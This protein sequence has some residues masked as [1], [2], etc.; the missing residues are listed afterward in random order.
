MKNKKIVV[1]I[2]GNGS[3]LQALIDATE[4]S[5]INATISAVI[6][7]RAGAYGLERARRGNIPTHIIEHTNFNDRCQFDLALQECIDQYQP[8]LVV[9]AGFLRILST[10]FVEHYHSRMLNIHPSLLPKYP[11][12]NTHQRAIEAGDTQHGTTVHFV[13]PELDS[14]PLIIQASR[15]IK[16]NKLPI[17]E[18]TQQL[19][20]QILEQ[21]H[22]IY[23]LAVKWFIEDRL[24]LGQNG[25]ELDGELLKAPVQLET[26]SEK[27]PTKKIG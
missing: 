8:D 5:Y 2:S 23:P 24:N 18:A 13:T 20:H 11:G 4:D 10:D 15:E 27:L 25:V 6:S 14:G 3:N 19:A 9:L 22:I 12:L 1:L 16:N 17:E 7:N 26:V 21:E